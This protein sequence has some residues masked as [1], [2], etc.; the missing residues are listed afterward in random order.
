MYVLIYMIMIAL[1]LMMVVPMGWDITYCGAELSYHH[2]LGPLF[3]G[4]PPPMG[5]TYTYGPLWKV[6]MKLLLCNCF[7]HASLSQFLK[8]FPKCHVVCLL[9]F[10][11]LVLQALP[12]CFLQ[13]S[14]KAQRW[15]CLQN[16]LQWMRW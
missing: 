2:V 16:K 6:L 14:G 15:G 4:L 12:Y 10:D 8:W 7:Q 9:K 5:F 13:V 11:N 3:W 1:C